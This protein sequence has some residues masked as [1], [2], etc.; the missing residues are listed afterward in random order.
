M[1]IQINKSLTTREGLT[2]ATGSIFYWDA[3]FI[4]YQIPNNNFVG[5]ASI[6]H[7]PQDPNFNI[8]YVG[9]NEVHFTIQWSTS[10][11]LR[12]IENRDLFRSMP[13]ELNSL[14]PVKNISTSEYLSMNSSQNTFSVVEG[15]L[16]E[17]IEDL[18]GASMST[19]VTPY[20]DNI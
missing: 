11:T 18:I 5:T 13:L 10:R 12:E 3:N 15:W 4:S 16:Q 20:Y 6:V 19:I 2:V 17:M 14:R 9:V 7:D 8:P 1:A